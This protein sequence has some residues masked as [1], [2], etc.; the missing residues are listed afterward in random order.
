MEECHIDR[1][2]WKK[3]C[4]IGYF[5][6]GLRCRLHNLSL[7]SLSSLFFHSSFQPSTITHTPTRFSHHEH[8]MSSSTTR[9]HI[10]TLA[11]HL[12]SFSHQ[13]G[14]ILLLL[15]ILIFLSLYLYNTHLAGR[16]RMEKGYEQVVWPAEFGFPWFYTDPKGGK[17]L[18]PWVEEPRET[19]SRG[20]VRLVGVLREFSLFSHLS[21]PVHP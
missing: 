9:H 20:H 7:P 5:G 1:S 21:L 11:N 15:P 10:R 18:V 12:P 6:C 17:D 13:S 19:S 8:S 14:N 16:L 4:N 2:D 3:R